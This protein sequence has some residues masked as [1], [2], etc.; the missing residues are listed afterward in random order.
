MN[1]PPLQLTPQERAI[2]QAI[3]REHIPAHTV[4]AFGSR[5]GRQP[6]PHS[7]LDLAI[8][9]PTPLPAGHSGQVA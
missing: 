6:K 4:W 5:A 1:Q 3:L 9:S 2:V 7:D 8:V